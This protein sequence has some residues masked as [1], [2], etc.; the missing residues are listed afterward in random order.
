MKTLISRVVVLLF[1][2]LA[3]LFPGKHLF[4]QATKKAPAPQPAA[5]TRAIGYG[6]SST[7]LLRRMDTDQD[8]F[9]TQD[10]W[11]RVFIDSDENRDK[12]LSPKEIESISGQIEKE[13]TLDPDQGR[14]AAFKRLDAN[15]ND[16]IDPSEWP[17]KD[18]D[19]HYLD[20]NGDGSLSRE[21]FLSRNGRWWNMPFE[22]LDFDGNGIIVRDEWLDSDA[23]FD[24]LDRDHNGVIERREFY[25]L[26]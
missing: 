11:D 10:E 3:L 13:K 14:L 2:A 17:G 19:F 18:T 12:R 1:I 8:G 16:A 4:A 20:A 15:H 24:M 5:G 7:D 26:R 22:N 23:S 6:L 21:E 9:I 25:R